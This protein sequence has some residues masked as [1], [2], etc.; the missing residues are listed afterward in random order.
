MSEAPLASL[1]SAIMAGESAV[2]VLLL[3]WVPRRI[4]I[5]G[6]ERWRRS[7]RIKAVSTKR[8]SGETQ[9]GRVG[10][11]RKMDGL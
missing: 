3:A 7:R 8:G 1:V 9:R 6:Q 4:I 5:R 11:G 10:S 2:R